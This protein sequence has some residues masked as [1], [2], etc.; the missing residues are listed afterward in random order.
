MT[1]EKHENCWYVVQTMQD[2]LVVEFNYFAKREESLPLSWAE[3]MI[4][5]LPVFKDYESAFAY[6][7][8]DDSLITPMRLR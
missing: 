3:G 2:N 4:G 1:E 7:E 6:A 5:A 8:G